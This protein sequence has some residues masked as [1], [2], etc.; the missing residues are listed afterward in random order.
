MN[1]RRVG[2]LYA[3]AAFSIWGL[4]PLYLKA[5]QRVAPLE[6]LA[7]RV[8]WAALFMIGVSAAKRSFRFLAAVR[9]D[10]KIFLTF[11]ASALVL[12]INWFVYI[13]SVNA[14]RV[15]DA[16]LGYFINPLFSVLLGVVVLG[17]RLRRAQW[18]SV[19][20][21]L[22]GVLWL[23]V[24]AGQLPWIGLTLAA[25]FGTYGLLRKT[26]ALGALEGLT[27]ETLLLLP[28]SA[29]YLVWR[30]AHEQSGFLQASPGLRA[31]LVLAG[32]LT[33]V[34]L[35][36]FSAGARKIPLSL[37]G[38]LQYVGPTL[39]LLLGVF[40]YREAFGPGKMAGYAFIWAALALYSAEGLLVSRRNPA[41][42]LE[43]AL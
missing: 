29:A 6:V 14:G 39:Q 7:H 35:L 12:S 31:L 43:R 27:L 2:I 19:A 9:A 8:F 18:V 28:L 41:P 23:T 42:A 3:L 15:V 40:L 17:E 21:A 37:V 38:I 1:P 10:R 32:P 13:W 36:L 25:S 24:L 4:L 11:A 34:P 5:V 20:L 30:G 26:A 33:A 22:T 16:S